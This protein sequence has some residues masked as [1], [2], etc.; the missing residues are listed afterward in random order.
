M[1]SCENPNHKPHKG[2][3]VEGCVEKGEEVG[4]GCVLR[5]LRVEGLSARQWESVEG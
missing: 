5:E 1:M 2:F 4:I 3:L